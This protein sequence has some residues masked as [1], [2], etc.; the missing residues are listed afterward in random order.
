MWQLIYDK[1]PW[2][3]TNPKLS[4]N[5]VSAIHSVLAVSLL[6]FRESVKYEIISFGISFICLDIELNRYLFSIMS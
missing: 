6:H 1:S 3:A 5:L 4:R 2:V